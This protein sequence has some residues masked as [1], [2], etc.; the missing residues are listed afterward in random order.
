M[1]FFLYPGNKLETLAGSDI[2]TRIFKIDNVWINLKVRSV[3]MSLNSYIREY[4]R[5]LSL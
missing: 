4:L 1:S 3:N 5:P 2:E